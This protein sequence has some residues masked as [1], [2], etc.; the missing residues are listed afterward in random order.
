MPACCGGAATRRGVPA[1]IPA[2]AATKL[3]YPNDMDYSLRSPVAPTGLVS[4]SAA[5]MTGAAGMT[6]GSHSRGS[7]NQTAIHKRLMDYSLRWS[8]APTW[9]VSGFAAGMTGAAGMTAKES[10]S[11]LG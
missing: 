10:G 6:A 5:G 3:P 7:A 11:L 1:V 8:V 4:G 9:L 2:E